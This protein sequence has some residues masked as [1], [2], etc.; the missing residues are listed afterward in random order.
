MQRLGFVASQAF[1]ET[2]T[3]RFVFIL[4]LA[5][6][7]VSH[8]QLAF[9]LSKE[10]LKL[11]VFAYF[12]V[13]IYCG[14]TDSSFLCRQTTQTFGDVSECQKCAPLFTSTITA[15]PGLLF[16]HLKGFCLSLER[17]KRLQLTSTVKGNENQKRNIFY[18]YS[19]LFMNE[20]IQNVSG[21]GTMFPR[22]NSQYSDSNSK[23]RSKKPFC[24]SPLKL[25]VVGEY[26]QDCAF[27]FE[28]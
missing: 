5:G 18:V 2:F 25:S 26:L 6:R 9:E 27:T 15:K 1:A 22:R 8:C 14:D 20:F 10:N 28:A 21:C 4:Q 23:R 16:K 3:H 13:N 11:L 7:R 17:Y 12:S 24:M 19:C